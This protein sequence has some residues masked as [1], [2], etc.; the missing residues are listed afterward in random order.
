[1]AFMSTPVPMPLRI[2]KYRITGLIGEGAMGVVYRAQDP[3]IQRSVAIKTIRAPLRQDT[4]DGPTAMRQFRVE[5]QAAGRLNHP[6]IVA[7][8]ESGEYGETG[9]ELFIAME[10][11]DGPSLSTLAKQ[12]DRLALPDVMAVMLQLLEAL[13]CAH[14]LR[15]WHCDIKPSNLL[16]GP[17][18]RIKVTDFGIAR[19]EASG[20]TL[21]N[22][23]WG[24][25]GYMAP[26]RFAGG[27]MD[28]RVDLFSCGVLLY[29]LLTGSAPF[30]GSA[31]SVM[32]QVL[33]QQPP[34]PSTLPGS[35]GTLALDAVVARAIA[36]HPGERFASAEDMRRALLEAAP[37]ART[38]RTLS[39]E[40]MAVVHRHGTGSQATLTAW[41][42]P[43]PPTLMDAVTAINLPVPQNVAPV[44][45]PPVTTGAPALPPITD[46]PRLGLAALSELE[47]LLRPCL[48][49]MS[50]IVVR[51]AARRSQTLAEVV[52]HVA[53]HALTPV[54]RPVFLRMARK[55]PGMAAAGVDLAATGSGPH[56]NADGPLVARTL[57]T[58]ETIEKAGRLL[59]RQAGPI[60]MLLA[61]RAASGCNSR[62]VFFQRLADEATEMVD[63]D[64][65]L[66]ALSRLD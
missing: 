22:A 14:A 53:D 66:A 28:Q 63:R 52:A 44:T 56:R 35:I 50:R 40:A 25:P 64:V 31:S 33:Q 32:Y 37:S 15:V 23:L 9:D 59:A 47:A 4:G 62:E 2:G 54:E 57:L 13:Q 39:R 27:A 21:R 24:S 8:Y 43:N 51:E 10:C 58:P 42:T 60:A 5:A 17:D 11:V 65:L 41:P 16:V 7:I 46:A 34:A 1:M 55:L 61:R 12:G 30:I 3:D 36:K 45:A 19:V 20:I 6:N 18:G 48:G 26:E 38:P 29:E 49:P